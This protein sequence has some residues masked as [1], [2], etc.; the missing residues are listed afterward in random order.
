MRTAASATLRDAAAVAAVV[1]LATVGKASKTAAMSPQ[2]LPLQVATRKGISNMRHTRRVLGVSIE[3]VADGLGQ[4]NGFWN[5]WNKVAMK[6]KGG[7]AGKETK[8]RAGW[9]VPWRKGKRQESAEL[10]DVL[11]HFAL[12]DLDVAILENWLHLFGR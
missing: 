3:S 12:R 6:R 9:R 5:K 1:P 2:N 4:V 10:V 7:G 8:E 11:A